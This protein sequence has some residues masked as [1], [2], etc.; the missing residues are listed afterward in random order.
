MVE[1]NDNTVIFAPRPGFVPVGLLDNDRAV[2]PVLVELLQSEDTEDL[3][4]AY[5][6]LIR[7][8]A[9]ADFTAPVVQHTGKSREE[10]LRDNALLALKVIDPEDSSQGWGIK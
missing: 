9:E 6:I 2:I 5:L 1:R 10:W 7:F 8:A 4:I 3:E